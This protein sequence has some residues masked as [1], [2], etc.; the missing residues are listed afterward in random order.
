MHDLYSQIVLLKNETNN[1]KRGRDFEILIREIQPWD[2][3]PPVVSSQDSEQLDGLFIYKNETY[4]IESKAVRKK[5]TPGMPEWEDFE[6]KLHRRRD[7]RVV[8]LFC[9]LFEVNKALEK[10]VHDLNMKG[11]TTIVITG[12][13]WEQLLESKIPFD[14][15]LNYLRLNATIKNKGLLDS[16]ENAMTWIYDTTSINQNFRDITFKV[17][18][19][20]LRRFK[21]RFHEQ[22]YINRKIDDQVSSIVRGMLP[23]N[24]KN[25]NNR[26]I[27]QQIIVLRDFSGCGKTTLAANFAISQTDYYCFA[28]VANHDSID[29]IPDKVLNDISYPALGIQELIAVN[30]PMVYIVDSL[31]EVP[32]QQQMH[33]RKEI[34]SLLKRLDELNALAHEYGLKNFPL[35]LIFTIREEYWRDWE[36]AFEGR[37]EVRQIKKALVNYNEAEFTKA[38]ANYEAAYHFKITNRLNEHSRDILSIPINLE[39]FSEANHY[40][41]VITV[42][43]IWEGKILMKFFDKKGEA[44]LK[45]YIDGYNSST[46]TRIL[47]SLAYELLLKKTTL[48]TNTDFVNVIKSISESLSL[49]SDQILINLISEQIIIT[50][51]EDVRSYRFK[52]NRFIDYLIALNVVHYVKDTGDFSYIDKSINDIYNSNFVSIFS[53]LTNLKHIARVQFT[54]IDKQI[55]DYYSHSHKYLSKLLPELRGAIARGEE[56]E[57]DVIKSIVANNYTEKAHFSWEIFFIVAAKKNLS[58]K[59]AILNSFDMAWKTNKELSY[60][61]KLIQKLSSRNLLMEEMVLLKLLS[62]GNS[63]EWEEYLGSVLMTKNEEIFIDLWEQ[64]QGDDRLREKTAKNPGEWIYAKR[65]LEL[66]FRGEGFIPGDILS[67]EKPKQYIVFEPVVD[68]KLPK[69]P[70]EAQAYCDKYVEEFRASFAGTPNEDPNLFMPYRVREMKKDSHLYINLKLSDLFSDKYGNSELPFLNYII[71]QHPKFDSTL[72]LILD[73]RELD[74]ALELSDKNK[75]TLFME[76]IESDYPWKAVLLEFIFLKGYGKKTA[77]DEYIRVM[78]AKKDEL[79]NGELE[80]LLIGYCFLKIKN[81]EGYRA[82]NEIYREISTLLS[83]KFGRIVSF[84]FSNMISVANN[85]L[86]HYKEFGNLF[87]HAFHIY[88]VYDSFMEKPSFAKKIQ[89][90]NSTNTEKLD[91]YAVLLQDLFP[92]LF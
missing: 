25:S 68:I 59:E 82:F 28:T 91:R 14:A 34:K 1:I 10:R 33:K 70:S 92:E 39:I 84:K 44:I 37:A 67:E 52:Y 2:Y 87:V 41:G 60:R 36:A 17:S 29:E 13:D 79:G 5:I 55:I 4:L 66:I 61:W 21:H 45:H 31:D 27:Y 65:L 56:I 90:S 76:I 62:D 69:L 78:L 8:G 40:D 72:K 89:L 43:D 63:R 15:F 26:D 80:S 88:D 58:K 50:D 30:K 75:R 49:Y 32:I 83:L 71:A 35:T 16:I 22:I 54:D 53:V 77:D 47:C 11:I 42:E 73:N 12:R 7:K 23:Q 57:K 64:T 85:A 24:L 46:F 48:F 81:K 6:L 9:C 74:I 51:F 19:S 38:L 20:F 18:G 86:E 3:R